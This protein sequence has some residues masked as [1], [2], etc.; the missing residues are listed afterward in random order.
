MPETL[1]FNI[2]VVDDD[3]ETI[4]GFETE[5]TDVELW[6]SLAPIRTCDSE[7]Q[8]APKIHPVTPRMTTA[9]AGAARPA[10][11]LK[12]YLSRVNAVLFGDD[13]NVGSMQDRAELYTPA[14]VFLVDWKFDKFNWSPKDGPKPDGLAVI[15]EILKRIPHAFCSLVTMHEAVDGGEEMHNLLHYSISKNALYDTAGRQRLALEISGYFEKLLSSPTW[16]GL[17]EYTTLPGD[18]FHAM[19]VN[20]GANASSTSAGFLKTL[21]HKLFAAQASLTLSPLDSLLAPRFDGCVAKSQDLFAEAFGAR[22]ARFGTNG[23][24][25]ANSVLWGSL[26]DRD[27]LVL[28]DRNCHISHHYAASIRGVTPI[29]LDPEI[30]YAPDVFGPP[31]IEEIINKIEVINKI[32]SIDR[33]KGIV[34]TNC[35]FDGNLI[36]SKKYIEKIDKKLRD[37]A[38]DT[39]ADKF[40]YFFDEAWFSFGRFDPR[41]IV[42]TAMFAAEHAETGHRHHR[43]RVYASQ[44]VHKTLTALRQASVILERDEWPRYDGPTGLDQPRFQQSFLAQTTTSPSM[45]ILASFDIARRQMSIDGA[46]MILQAEQA[47]KMFADQLSNDAWSTVAAAFSTQPFGSTEERRGASFPK[48]PTKLTL[49]HL[50]PAKSGEAKK[51]LWDDCLIQVNKFGIDSVMFMFMPGFDRARIPNVLSKLSDLVRSI[52]PCRPGLVQPPVVRIAIERCV[53][54]DGN[55]RSYPTE[56]VQSGH[57]GMGETL[58]GPNDGAELL[59][60]N[61][62]NSEED[63]LCCSFITPYPPGFPIIIPGQV[64][65][66]RI[67]KEILDSE[68]EIH[69][70]DVNKAVLLRKIK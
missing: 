27:D 52:D 40:I 12:A 33:L 61:Q 13:P 9:A 29:Y 25:G 64:V 8:L 17:M 34:L 2:I 67:M 18:V 28:V 53:D 26:F 41:L 5:M 68:D 70:I 32:N 55:V 30:E 10:E 20:Q 59:N 45:P 11:D 65:S 43:P 39:F 24:S 15:Q 19:A 31:S 7:I 51:R 21:G 6:R 36:E 38:N 47:V 46:E 48:D 63:Y 58:F 54:Q 14:I 23:T 66:G 49:F 62:I 16:D 35:T 50:L 60:S 3:P 56:V 57:I 4:A 1:N 42:Y 44:S 69:G 22:R 37:I